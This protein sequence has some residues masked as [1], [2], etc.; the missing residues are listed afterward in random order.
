MIYISINNK[1]VWINK[2]FKVIKKSKAVWIFL[3]CGYKYFLY[4]DK[5]NFT[6]LTQLFFLLEKHTSVLHKYQKIQSSLDFSLLWL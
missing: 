2:D 6:T 4:D 1:K 3:S 5:E